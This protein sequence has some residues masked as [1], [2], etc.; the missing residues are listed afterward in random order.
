[1]LALLVVI[2][3][4]MPRTISSDGARC[5]RSLLSE[6]VPLPDEL[7]RLPFPDEEVV[8]L[9]PVPDVEEERREKDRFFAFGSWSGEVAR[10][11]SIFTRDWEGNSEE[12]LRREGRRS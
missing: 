7:L 5:L 4:A 12:E 8:T 3:L 10:F 6:K 2:E 11:P 9:P 1:M